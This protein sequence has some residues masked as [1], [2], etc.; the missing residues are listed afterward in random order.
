MYE[1]GG[2]AD[3]LEFALAKVRGDAVQVVCC[4][5]FFDETEIRLLPS[6]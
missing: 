1:N 6:S 2:F 5:L 4:F 3:E